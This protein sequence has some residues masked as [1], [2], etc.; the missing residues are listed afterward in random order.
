VASI[1]GVAAIIAAALGAVNHVKIGEVHVLV[2]NRLDSALEQI[3]DLQKQR[4][5]LQGEEDKKNV[6][7]LHC[8]SGCYPC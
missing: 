3:A 1:S 4:D 6:N 5:R 8:S 2:N 7:S